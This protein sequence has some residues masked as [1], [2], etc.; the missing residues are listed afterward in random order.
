MRYRR[1]DLNLLV[2]LDALLEECNVSRAAERLHLGQS[3]TS[4][5]WRGCA[6]T[7][8]PLLVPLGRRLE[9][10]A[11]ARALAPKVREALALTGRSS[12]PRCASSR[13]A[14]SGVSPWWRRT[15]SPRAAAGG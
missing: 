13:R 9:P 4:A 15:M 11:L 12:M 3:A 1:L 7:Q 5:R 6:N 2:A 14:A 8:R 10:S